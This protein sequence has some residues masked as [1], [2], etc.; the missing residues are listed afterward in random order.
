MPA[1]P[2][3]ESYHT[4]TPY[5]TVKGANALI[6]F[7]TRAF[8]ATEAH[9][10]RGPNGEVQHGDLMVGDSHVMVG[11]AGAQWPPMPAQ[12]YLYL[13]DCDAVYRQAIAAGGISIQEPQTQF[14]GDRHGAVKDP[15]GNTWW[16]ATHVED[17]PPEELATRAADPARQR[18]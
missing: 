5:L 12:L 11:E 2:V 18:S 15:C 7:I 14:Y 13:P 8:G 9:V 3:P 10:M 16:I 4:V 6:D 1:K 17:V